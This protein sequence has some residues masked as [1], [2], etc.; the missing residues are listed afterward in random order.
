MLNNKPSRIAAAV[1]LAIGLSATATA[2]ETSSSL[3]GVI[4]SEQTGEVIGNA[5]ILLTDERT[6]TSRTLTANENGLFSARGLAVGGPYTVVVTD[7]L[8]NEKRIENVFL[9]LGETENLNVAV[10]QQSVERIAVTGRTLNM[11]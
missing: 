11:S 9:T 2:Q 10:E 5:S 7:N 3:R 8:G 6:G 1:A 4:V